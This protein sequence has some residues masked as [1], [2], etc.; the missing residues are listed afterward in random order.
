LLPT[1]RFLHDPPPGK[2][3]TGTIALLATPHTAAVA[4]ILA[5][6]QAGALV[7]AADSPLARELSAKWPGIRL[8][9][10]RQPREIAQEIIA[11]AQK[12]SA[13]QSSPELNL[14]TFVPRWKQFYE[15]VLISRSRSELVSV[16]G[17]AK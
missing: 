4:P 6:M 8:L 9:P 13:A 16:T 17:L 7:L 15:D 11:A 2:L 10:T 1:K 5:A 14:N 3:G 12:H